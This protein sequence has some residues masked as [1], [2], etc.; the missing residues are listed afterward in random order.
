M[1]MYSRCER[2]CVLVKEEKTRR[3]ERTQG[4]KDGRR[5]KRRRGNSQREG[6]AL[7]LAAAERS[8]GAR[9]KVR[10]QKSLPSI[11]TVKPDTHRKSV[12]L[13]YSADAS[14]SQGHPR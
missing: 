13:E 6:R 2:L 9:V 14:K 12:K 11:V 5:D 8:G 7:T 10:G 4:E 1:K 3:R